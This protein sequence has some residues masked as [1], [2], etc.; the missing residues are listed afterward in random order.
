M[1]FLKTLSLSFLIFLSFSVAAQNASPLE[2]IPDLDGFGESMR[3]GWKV[4]MEGNSMAVSIPGYDKGVIAVFEL[5][6]GTWVLKGKLT[7][8]SL[9][10]Y[11]SIGSAISFRN[12]TIV[13][14]ILDEIYVF[15]KPAGGWQ[16]MQETAVLKALPPS[17]TEYLDELII[18]GNR[19]YAR[20]TYTANGIYVFEKQPGASWA[21]QNQSRRLTV[22]FTISNDYSQSMAAAENYVVLTTSDGAFVFEHDSNGQWLNGGNQVAKLLVSNDST[23]YF[24]VG[25]SASKNTI[26]FSAEEKYGESQYSRGVAYTFER[27]GASWA[28]NEIDTARMFSPYTDFQY[29]RTILLQDTVLI[30][31]EGSEDVITFRKAGDTWKNAEIMQTFYHYDDARSF[32]NDLALSGKYLAIASYR[33]YNLAY[34]SGAVYMFEFDPATLAYNEVQRL[35]IDDAVL[36][37]NSADGD[38]FGFDVARNDS[39]MVIGSPRD[40]RNGSDSGCVYVYE[41][42]N[43][44][45]DLVSVLTASDAM[46]MAYFGWAVDIEDDVIIVGSP[47]RDSNR[48]AVYYYLRN[49]NSWSAQ[50]VEH[51][52]PIENSQPDDY[53]GYS[54]DISGDAMFASIPGLDKG[55][56]KIYGKNGSWTQIP[57]PLID[58]FPFTAPDDIS[59]FGRDLDVS[60]NH[61][62][63]GQAF[64][65]T[66]NPRAFLFEKQGELWNNA[67]NIAELKPSD[68]SAYHSEFFSAHYF[69]TSV[70]IDDTVVVVSGYQY[71][72]THSAYVFRKPAEG[73]MD[74]VETSKVDSDH[75]DIFF[76]IAMHVDIVENRMT[77]AVMGSTIHQDIYL[78][79]SPDGSWTEPT[80][81]ETW[82]DQGY[83]A[84]LTPEEIIMSDFYNNANTGKVT[85]IGLAALVSGNIKYAGSVIPASIEVPNLALGEISAPYTLTFENE[86][87]TELSVS[88]ELSG[89]LSTENP[90]VFTIPANELRSFTFTVN[91]DEL[92]ERT[93]Q[94]TIHSNIPGFELRT[95]QVEVLVEERV[96]ATE[97]K[98]ESPAIF[99]NPTSHELNIRQAVGKRFSSAKLYDTTGR[100]AFET[101]EA[102][103]TDELITINFPSLKPGLYLLLI[104]N[105]TMGSIM[106][107]E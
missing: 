12:N 42:N 29:S 71:G 1:K 92:G 44:D 59:F 98:P 38:Y 103:F 49:G 101:R 70:A 56:V 10:M 35:S 23:T 45:W 8:A 57:D 88:V 3:F 62:I 19:I 15:E 55:T 46:D 43:D 9:P 11:S 83:Y 63:V 89:N 75:T 65:N 74:M 24:G 2:F 95:I 27:S 28:D 40:D 33:E 13:T 106:I 54:V 80:R 5:Q 37:V 93:G 52:L 34:E 67:I 58:L 16:D 20:S 51:T 97:K 90:T 91:G 32:A 48:G 102:S 82:S 31:G 87:M 64:N 72:G 14:S 78:Y 41:K 39:V 104:D 4:A 79:V 26:A 76:S 61:I 47:N 99:P 68:A 94:V 60:G 73:W 17:G 96:V 7:A 36:Q 21:G 25:I 53:F 81:I 105:E 18:E 84:E 85:I 6:N 50:P 77:M 66:T 100:L 30:F 22:N 107:Q 86:G 69:G